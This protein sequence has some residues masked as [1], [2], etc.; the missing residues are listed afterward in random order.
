[1]TE[2]RK[3]EQESR[4]EMAAWIACGYLT[5]RETLADFEDID[6]LTDLI[7][8]EA[9][10]ALGQPR[11]DVQAEILGLKARFHAVLRPLLQADP[12]QTL[13][14]ALHPILK[15][16]PAMSPGMVLHWLTRQA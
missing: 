16:H 12:E 15:A 4:D 14:E 6:T 13:L 8:L 10:G 5:G 2:Q 11:P 3:T 1:M 9:E 7:L